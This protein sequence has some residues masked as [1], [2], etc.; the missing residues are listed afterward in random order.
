MLE[1]VKVLIKSK[2]GIDPREQLIGY[3]GR[4]LSPHRTLAELGIDHGT[5]LDLTLQLRGGGGKGDGKGIK[6]DSDT[7]RMQWRGPVSRL[8]RIFVDG[9]VPFRQ[10]IEVYIVFGAAV[11]RNDPDMLPVFQ[12]ELNVLVNLGEAFDGSAQMRAIED[13]MI[14]MMRG[15]E[16]GRYRSSQG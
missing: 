1:D 11:A 4:M 16:T 6:G 3:Q 10:R 9:G 14:E 8:A 2:L 7:H 15:L 13:G 12:T 5:T